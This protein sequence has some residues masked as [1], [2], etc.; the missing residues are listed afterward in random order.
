VAGKLPGKDPLSAVV[1]P[2]KVTLVR[3]TQSANAELEIR[4]TFGGIVT[5]VRPVSLKWLLPIVAK[6]E[7]MVTLV[8]PVIPLNTP[9]V[10][11]KLVTLS[12][13]TTLVILVASRNELMVVTGLPSLLEGMT[14]APVI[15]LLIG[16]TLDTPP[17]RL[18]N[19]S[20]SIVGD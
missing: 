13:I 14:T 5:L 15:Q 7:P 16:L 20:L 8:R 1:G 12:G 2:R 4:V 19:F 6:P 9:C 17:E 3:F 10:E 11:L 18:L